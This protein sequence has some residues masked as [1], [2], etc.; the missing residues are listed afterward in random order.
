MNAGLISDCQS[1]RV[2]QRELE[3]VLSA[4]DMRTLQHTYTSMLPWHVRIWIWPQL[5]GYH[6]DDIR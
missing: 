5:G 1:R 3:Y 6:A 4:D 2:N